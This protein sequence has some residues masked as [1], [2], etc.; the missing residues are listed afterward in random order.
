MHQSNTL[1]E[2]YDPRSPGLEQL[3]F[4]VNSWDSFLYLFSNMCMR[5]RIRATV[6]SSS[7]VCP[8]LSPP[9]KNRALVTYSVSI[10]LMSRPRFAAQMRS[11]LWTH[12]LSQTRNA[13]PL[14]GSRA[15]FERAAAPHKMQSWS[16]LAPRWPSLTTN[17]NRQ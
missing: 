14:A 3:C 5:P 17:L 11:E 6:C 8:F 1:G 16:V 10:L 15:F 12:S 9:K 2:F 13:T 4:F 7:S